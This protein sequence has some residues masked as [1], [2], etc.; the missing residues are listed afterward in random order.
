MSGTVI[1]CLNSRSWTRKPTEEN[2]GYNKF[3]QKKKKESSSKRIKLFFFSLINLGFQGNEAQCEPF[4]SVGAA[5]GLFWLPGSQERLPVHVRP[6]ETKRGSSVSGRGGN[7]LEIL[8]M[9][10]KGEGEGGGGWGG[11]GGGGT[12]DE[13]KESRGAA[14]AA[15]WKAVQGKASVN[16]QAG[17]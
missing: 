9:R 7:S 17:I 3:H 6:G 2:Q 12:P 15:D 10:G 14:V 1:Y 13:V 8:R 4:D 16:I 5:R 11:G